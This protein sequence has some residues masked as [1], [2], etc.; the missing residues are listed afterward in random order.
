MPMKNLVEQ[1]KSFAMDEGGPT[2]VEYGVLLALI[3]MAAVVAITLLG[4][5]SN[6]IFTGVADKLP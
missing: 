6:E 2:A 3:V 5:K 4:Q 1:A